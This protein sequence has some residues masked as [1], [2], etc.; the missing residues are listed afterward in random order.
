MNKKQAL[1]E[2]EEHLSEAPTELKKYAL[3]S[4]KKQAEDAEI[5]AWASQD[6]FDWGESKEKG[7]FWFAIANEDWEEAQAEL[8]KLNP[9]YDHINSD[10]YEP[11]WFE[12][13]PLRWR[14]IY[15]MAGGILI[16]YLLHYLF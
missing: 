3:K 1:A 14:Y 12:R 10:D 4:W 6:F 8:S 9:A 7:N 11:N 16:G 15:H 2:L 13:L 5:I